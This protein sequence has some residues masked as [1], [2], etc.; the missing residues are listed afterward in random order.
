MQ[1]VNNQSQHI[2]SKLHILKEMEKIAWDGHEFPQSLLPT[3]NCPCLP[4]PQFL[5]LSVQ[6]MEKKGNCCHHCS[7]KTVDIEGSQEEQDVIHRHQ[8]SRTDEENEIY[9]HMASK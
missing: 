1:S 6:N 7:H 8:G 5:L 2:T 4:V 3:A 9:Y